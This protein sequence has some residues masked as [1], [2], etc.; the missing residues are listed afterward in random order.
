MYFLRKNACPEEKSII[1]YAL[2]FMFLCKL[3]GKNLKQHINKKD[4]V[5]SIRQLVP[6]ELC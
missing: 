1:I 3:G 4:Q 5:L 6:M 2:I